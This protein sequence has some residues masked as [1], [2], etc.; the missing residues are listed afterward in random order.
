MIRLVD[1]EPEWISVDGRRVGIS[2]SC[3]CCGTFRVAVQFV[4][5]IEGG[6]ALP[7][8]HRRYA[9]HAGFRWT[10]SGDTFETLSIS[11][12]VLATKAHHWV[13]HVSAG[14]VSP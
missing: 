2:F 11:P 10:R 4:N 1:L 13:G 3:P 12:V 9:D 14:E 5:P 8:D 7:P 6:A